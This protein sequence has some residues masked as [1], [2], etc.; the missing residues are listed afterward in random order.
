[1]KSLKIYL[2]FL[3]ISIIFSHC[4][5]D[6]GQPN[7]N[8]QTSTETPKVDEAVLASDLYKYYHANPTNQF[9]KDENAIIELAV[10][11]GWQMNRTN[12][13]LYYLIKQQGEGPNYL[14]GQP[15]QA[16]YQGFFLDGKMFDSS[17]KR[18][19]P[20]IFSVGQMIAGWN[21]AQ[22]LVNPGT[23]MLILVP[24][25]LAYGERGFPGFVPPNTPIMFDIEMLRIN[26]K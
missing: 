8:T 20:I 22:Q 25:K 14:M 15:A 11:K 10:D 13:G 2:L 6:N 7:P 23:K 16:N 24:S 5:N 3:L 9:E 26:S 18:N 1:M 12:S 17:Y 4:K 21:E 19:K